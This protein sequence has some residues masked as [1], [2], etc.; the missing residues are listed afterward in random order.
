MNETLYHAAVLKRRIAEA[1]QEYEMIK[2]QV[3]FEIKKL[4][5][6][7]EKPTVEVG[8]LGS[9]SLA[10]YRTWT[11]SLFIQKTE[12]ELLEAK[13]TEQADGTA[14]VAEKQI[15]KFIVKKESPH[16]IPQQTN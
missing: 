3:A 16:E 9:F 12:K 1:E 6:G 13:K 11:Y 8:E 5:A 14:A 15:V 7:A 2:E 10:T 4:T